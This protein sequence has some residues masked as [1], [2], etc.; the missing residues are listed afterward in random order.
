ME[1][2]TTY[3]IY[4]IYN[5]DGELEYVGQSKNLGDRVPT[6]RSTRFPSNLYDYYVAQVNTHAD[7]N[8]YE[9]F[10][11][12]KLQPKKNS[13]KKRADKPT[14]VLPE[15]NFVKYEEIQMVVKPKR[16]T[17]K[18]PLYIEEEDTFLE[19]GYKIPLF[20]FKRSSVNPSNSVRYFTSKSEYL[21][22]KTNNGL[23]PI[24]KEIFLLFLNEGQREVPSKNMLKL[25]LSFEQIA[26]HALS[27]DT[28]RNSFNRL[29]SLGIE[30]NSEY[31]LSIFSSSWPAYNH[32]E[33]FISIGNLRLLNQF[34]IV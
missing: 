14:V 4:K 29:L 33:A 24:D 31:G 22:I 6:H 20:G 5:K 23:E 32:K 21:I 13:Q 16:I 9:D 27:T 30:F 28:L 3:W 19:E 7:M 25:F 15:L 8:I 17:N 34:E 11:I 12:S 1:D 10:Y 18:S 26:E 2:K